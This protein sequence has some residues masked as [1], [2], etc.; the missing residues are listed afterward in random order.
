MGKISL[1]YRAKYYKNKSGPQVT[2]SICRY[3]ILCLSQSIVTCM[4]VCQIGFFCANVNA[5]DLQDCIKDEQRNAHLHLSICSSIRSTSINL[6]YF[7]LPLSVPLSIYLC[8]SCVLSTFASHQRRV[9][10]I[11]TRDKLSEWRHSEVKI[12]FLLNQKVTLTQDVAYLF[13]SR[14]RSSSILVVLWNIIN[15]GGWLPTYLGIKGR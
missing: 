14:D 15:P 9:I 13:H 10:E 12:I 11:W 1:F 7:H 5:W 4:F 3:V 6:T 2:L 8:L